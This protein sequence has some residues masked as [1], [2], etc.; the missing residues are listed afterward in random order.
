MIWLV[1]QFIAARIRCGGFNSRAIFVLARNRHANRLPVFDLPTT[2][3]NGVPLYPSTAPHGTSSKFAAFL[4][5]ISWAK[6]LEDESPS[7]GI[8]L[9]CALAWSEIKERFRE[10]GMRPIPQLLPPIAPHNLDLSYPARG[11]ETCIHPHQAFV[12][13]CRAARASQ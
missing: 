4:V 8:V 12:D 2:S 9:C 11:Y 1:R 13:A 10:I 6:Y 5:G 7:M 3:L